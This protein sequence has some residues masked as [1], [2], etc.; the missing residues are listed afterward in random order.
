MVAVR[1]GSETG[2]RLINQGGRQV[3]QLVGKA[4]EDLIQWAKITGKAIGT[5]HVAN[6]VNSP[7]VQKSGGVI[8]LA[9]LLLNSWN[10]G[11]YLSQAQVLEGVDQQRQYET[12]S[13]TLYAAAALVAVIDA[14][15]R[16]GFWGGHFYWRQ[17]IR[18]WFCQVLIKFLGL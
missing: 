8:A 15:V 4:A 1:V 7:A 17:K 16:K 3:L 14:Q 13:A 2:L 10:A 6:I 5:G 18:I 9:A 11:R 12:A